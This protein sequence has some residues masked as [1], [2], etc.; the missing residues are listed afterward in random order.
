MRI[1]SI[2]AAEY[3]TAIAYGFFVCFLQGKLLK[4]VSLHPFKTFLNNLLTNN[5]KMCRCILIYCSARCRTPPPPAYANGKGLCPPTADT[6]LL[7]FLLFPSV[8]KIGTVLRLFCRANL[9]KAS[10]ERAHA[11]GEVVA[12]TA[13]LQSC[14][15]LFTVALNRFVE[16]CDIITHGHVRPITV[17]LGQKAPLTSRARIIC[18][19]YCFTVILTTEHAG[20]VNE[21]PSSVI[22]TPSKWPDFTFSGDSNVLNA[23]ILSVRISASTDAGL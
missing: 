20:S 23:S 3:S 11:V 18:V 10:A 9:H 6:A 12:C 17:Y 2:H 22:F 8:W 1:K 19:H 16:R 7:S 14:R 15:V 4:K 13:Y 21:S 5:Y